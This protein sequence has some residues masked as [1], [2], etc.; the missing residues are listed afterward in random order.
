MYE[1]GV[2]CTDCH[3]P[4]SLELRAEGDAVCAQCHLPEHYEGAAHSRHADAPEA[5]GCRDCHMPARNYMVVDPRRDHSFR[6]PRPD[7]AASLGVTD[8]CAACHGD[9]PAGWSAA[10]V[11]EWLGRD[12]AGLQQFAAAFAAAE[13]GDIDAA[14]DLRRI[15]TDGAQPA[16]VRGTALTLLGRYP[17]PI[18]V[19][20]AAGA[21][22]DDD[23]AVRL[24]AMRS[25]EA[26][27]PEERL[28]YLRPL[29]TDP[30]RA[31]RVEAARLLAG[32]DPV[33]LTAA[34][35]ETL[36]DAVTEYVE[37]QR[38]SLD[39]PSAWLNLGNLYLQSGDAEAAVEHYRGALRLDADFEPAYGN[40]ADLLARLGQEAAAGAMLREGLLRHPDSAT[41][42]HAFGL[43]RI[44]ADERA[45]ALDSL[46]RAVELAPDD[47]RFRYVYAIALDGAGEKEQALAELAEAHRRYPA[48]TDVLQAL[49]GLHLR[50]GNVDEAQAYARTLLRL[51]PDDAE[52]QSLLDRLDGR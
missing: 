48:D 17:A 21:M 51:T 45:A 35:R 10:A 7:L 28:E 39:R 4:H 16:I 27:P 37:V 40:L 3:E 50:A 31:V 44:R 18:A 12:A 5:P 1:A 2:V 32:I 25:M 41:L 20:T 24:A 23:P 33:F 46:A 22:R 13:S 38:A 52:L 26:T 8:A 11:Q 9:K 29:L 34:E 43:H 15:A 49:V 19:A 47:S 6:V 30:V 14:A 36:N 42:H